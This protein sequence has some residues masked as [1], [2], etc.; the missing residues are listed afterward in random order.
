MKGDLAK[1]SKIASQ[2]MELTGQ[3]VEIF[4]GRAFN[5]V[6]DNALGFFS[7]QLELY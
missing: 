7:K 2:V 1:V 3:L 6:K 5:V 4:K